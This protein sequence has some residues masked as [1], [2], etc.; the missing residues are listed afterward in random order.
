MVFCHFFSFSLITIPSTVFCSVKITKSSSAHGKHGSARS[1]N[2]FHVTAGC[3]TRSARSIS[4]APRAPAGIA[5]AKLPGN[6]VKRAGSP[7]FA[8]GQVL[9][10]AT[11]AFPA[12]SLF[13][14]W[15]CVGRGLWGGQNITRDFAADCV[16]ASRAV[17]CAL[18]CWEKC[19]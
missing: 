15:Q 18:G 8:A 1:T 2:I 5:L 3:E 14:L 17:P 12:L 11:A 19:Y 4:P 7:L 13:Y 16:A 9:T 6:E 10:H